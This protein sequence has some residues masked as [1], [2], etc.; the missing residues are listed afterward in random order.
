MMKMRMTIVGSGHG[1]PEAN[2]KCSCIMIEE[3]E[4]LYFIDMGTSAMNALRDRGRSVES[5]RGVFITHMHGDHTDGLVEF[6]D[7]ITWYFT[8]A[9]PVVVLPDLRA[10]DVLNDWLEVTQNGSSREIR[11]RRTQA[12]VVYDDHVLKVTAIPTQHCEGSHAYLLETENA[13]VLCTG[14]LKGP[15]VDFPFVKGRLD[16]LIC[17]CAHFPATSYLPVF[18]NIDVDWICFTHYSPKR[19]QSL[20]EV[21]QKLVESGKTVTIAT[22]NLELDIQHSPGHTLS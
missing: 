17:E 16:C 13:R 9:D 5:V 2:R 4:N 12:G 20:Y 11:Y 18:E 19:M 21:R 7:L 22:D 1:V 3:G 14:D 15:S 6:I 8:D 10:R